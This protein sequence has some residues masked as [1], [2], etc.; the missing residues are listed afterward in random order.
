MCSR[1]V[2]TAEAG[3]EGGGGAFRSGC[4]PSSRPCALATA[5]TAFAAFSLLAA[6]IS[7]WLVV[8][9]ASRVAA[10]KDRDAEGSDPPGTAIPSVARNAQAGALPG[11][12]R[13]AGPVDGMPHSRGGAASH[14][15][16]GGGGGDSGHAEASWGTFVGDSPL[17]AT[18][19][20]GGEPEDE[21]E[22]ADAEG[23]D[24]DD[25]ELGLL[26]AGHGAELRTLLP[27]SRG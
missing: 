13:G 15:L 1:I 14:W 20:H 21:G 7:I 19:L 2:S 26:A 4:V 23:T 18:A 27:G 17:P 5:A 10:T 22:D 6:A 11:V 9:S 3:C 12:K 25:E 16:S 24:G 8:Q